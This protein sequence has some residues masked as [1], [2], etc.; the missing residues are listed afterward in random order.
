[1]ETNAKH[2]TKK[3][4]RLID[5]VK[6]GIPNGNITYI[7]AFIIPFTILLVLYIGR[8]IFP[9]GDK[10]Y[11]R[12]D[13][14]HQYGPFF[15][16]MWHKMRNGES[17]LYSWDNGMGTN[18]IS[19]MAYYLAS[20]ANW[21]IALFP[22]KYIVEVMN[23]III[24]K[25]SFSSVTLS[26]YIIKH[27]NT[28]KCTIALFGMFYA[29][30]GYVAAYSWNIMWLDCILLLP[31]IMLGLERLV[32]ENKCFLYCITL[33]LCI[34]TNYYIAIMVCMSVVIYYVVLIIAYD[35]PKNPIFYIKK[36]L[37]WGFY[38]LL[39]GGLAACLLLPEIYTFSLSSSST[40]SFPKRLTAYFSLLEMF[41]RQMVNVEV[42][43]GLEHHPNMYC[44]VAVLLLIP[45]YIM[46]KKINSREKI[47][48]SIILLI[49]LLSFNLNVLNFIWHGFHFPNSLP[50]RQAFI[51]IFFLLT[52]GFE[53]LHHIKSY[54]KR[55]FTTAVWIPLILLFIY[56][57]IFKDSKLYDFKIFYISGA[58]ILVYAL[59]MYL[60]R[61]KGL[62]T[63]IIL[64]AAFLT[65]IMECA[66]NMEETG[67]GTTSRTA[68]LLDYD[69]V[70]TVTNTVYQQ[71]ESFYRMDKITG[72]RSKNDGSWHN[73]HSIST[74]SST[75]NAG[76]SEL[77][78]NIGLIGSTNA[79]AYDG[80]TMVTNSLFSV[81]Y[82][83]SNQHLLEDSLRTYY[84]GNNGEFIYQNHYTLP[85]GYMV[86]EKFLDW[87]YTSMNNGIDNQN[88]MIKAMT[89]IVHV[90][91]PVQEFNAYNEISYIASKTG[92]MYVS[93]HPSGNNSTTIVANVGKETI[94]F[95]NLKNNPHTL[96]LGYVTEGTYIELL[97]TSPITCTVY[98]LNEDKFID[99]YNKLND[100]ALNI[101]KWS[102]TY[103]KGNIN[104]K[105]DN[106]LLLSIPYDEGWSVY[107][108][109]VKTETYSVLNALTGIDL[110]AGEHTIEIKYFPVNL[111]MGC[112]I[113]ALCII[114]LI[115][116]YIIKR[117]I[118]NQKLNTTKLP[119]LIQYLIDE[120]D[121]FIP[122]KNKTLSDNFD[123]TLTNK[124]DVDTITDAQ[125][126]KEIASGIEDMND[127]DNIELNDDD[128][129]DESN[130]TNNKKDKNDEK[131]E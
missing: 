32:K 57:Y 131:G 17:L 12:S 40:I 107:V 9:F 34:F 76:M 3:K 19:L 38:S 106:T 50:C 98:T 90:F 4:F 82:L 92:H 68:Y 22:Q 116:V 58:F 2:S 86:P 35:G 127:F 100:E 26:H 41:A 6:G 36:T 55:Q 124:A 18:F 52:M 103:F 27:F 122:K 59:L 53:A 126:M 108:D 101:T 96:D 51:Y 20:P 114:I 84:T 73:Y 7:L 31:L 60:R 44:G 45:L 97:V 23:A 5:D 75:S 56:D 111:I 42:H 105:S 113:T 28:K 93:I 24:L 109:G 123:N 67:L 89:D 46:C 14:Y 121:K 79:Y 13:M 74:F 65:A 11:M 10:Y 80:S 39:S 43:M 91:E 88:S 115:A 102:D 119:R 1:M 69:A 64:F 87:H 128:E 54:S 85:L 77:Y 16:E 83:I 95:D 120:D 37:N 63:P 125:L 104:V 70:K 94:E 33:G 29:L 62:K 71:D 15:S 72:A 61:T 21:I 81:K 30:S 112:I 47:G 8:E 49:F 78:K 118:K 66:I 25:L 99:L 130:D 48:K 117:S 110:T 129:K